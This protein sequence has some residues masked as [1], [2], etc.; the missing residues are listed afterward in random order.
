[1]ENH[2]ALKPPR[3]V[4]KGTSVPDRRAGFSRVGEYR[5]S[6]CRR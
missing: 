2:M 3:M 4:E 6:M 1:M 5:R